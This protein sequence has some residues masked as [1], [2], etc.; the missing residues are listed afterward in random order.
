MQLAFLVISKFTS[1]PIV[2]NSIPTTRIKFRSTKDF[3][4]VVMILLTRCPS[5][6]YM[7]QKLTDRCLLARYVRSNATIKSM[8]ASMDCMQNK[9]FK[10][11]RSCAFPSFS[12]IFLEAAKVA[13]S[14]AQ[15]KQHRG[16]KQ[17]IEKMLR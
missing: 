9:A 14:R 10:K 2:S 6:K 12:I 13:F 3:I 5:S 15:M 7:P 4:G 8:G 11:T 1:I 17:L 16:N